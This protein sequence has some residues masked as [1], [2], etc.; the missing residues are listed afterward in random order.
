VTRVDG[1]PGGPA[2]APGAG[3]L[4]PVA[5]TVVG[6]GLGTGVIYAGGAWLC[7]AAGGVSGF[8]MAALAF[9]GIGSFVTLALAPVL[10]MDAQPR[11]RALAGR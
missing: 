7:A 10:L 9:F 3:W 4:A 6:V 5:A 8:A 1:V 2:R 11:R